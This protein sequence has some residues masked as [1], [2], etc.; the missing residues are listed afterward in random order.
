MV[1]PADAAYLPTS[2]PSRLAPL[3]NAVMSS[4]DYQSQGQKV[5]DNMTT[6]GY[7]ISP[8]FM[9]KMAGRFI[10]LYKAVPLISDGD[11]AVTSTA[12]DFEVVEC[13]PQRL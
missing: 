5:L 4:S 8:A 9:D 13:N 6:E 1:A 2:P 12:E 11:T 3:Q 10:K 7:Y